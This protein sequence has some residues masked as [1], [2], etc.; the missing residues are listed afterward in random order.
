MISNMKNLYKALADF[1]SQCPVILKESSGHN[2]KYSDLPA[3][4]S[5]I[6]PILKEN[7]LAVFQ[8]LT[9]LDG[10]IAIKTIIV[11]T[12]S[13]ESIEDI[14]PLPQTTFDKVTVKKTDAKTGL[15][16]E[17]S[18]SVVVGFEQMSQ[19]QAQGSI[20]TYYRRYCL[21]SV[22]GLITDKDTDGQGKGADHDL[23]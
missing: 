16:T 2:Y 17:T 14:H 5:V 20:I 18:K 9:N 10:V 3:I 1:Q 21:S 13:G 22:L 15:V 12:E 19:P 4:Y 6:N 11:H 8:P 7:N 23:Y